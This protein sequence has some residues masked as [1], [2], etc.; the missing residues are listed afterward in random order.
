MGPILTTNAVIMCPHGGTV[1]I[2]PRPG[3]M[4]IQG[5]A[6]LC[7]G[8]LVGAPILGCTVAPTATSK[9]CLTVVSTLPGSTTPR[10]LVGVRPAYVATLT[11]VTDGAPP[12]AIAVVTSPGQTRMTG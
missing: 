9:P 7:E 4:M 6:V 11:A 2:A 3:R 5:G 8:D 10:V 1:T 12:P